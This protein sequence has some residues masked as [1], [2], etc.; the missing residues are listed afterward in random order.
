MSPRRLTYAPPGATYVDGFD[1]LVTPM[2]R[3]FYKRNRR[4]VQN[5]LAALTQAAMP[6]AS[7]V[8]WGKKA[9]YATV[10]EIRIPWRGDV[11]NYLKDILDR[12]ARQG[13]FGGND[14]RIDLVH[15]TK[16][17][18]VPQEDVGARVEIWRLS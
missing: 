4:S 15:A 12:S 6:V 7:R 9:R 3:S 13:I 10:I 14:E 2:A 18:N 11:D 5:W 1:V 8:K 17:V 16:L